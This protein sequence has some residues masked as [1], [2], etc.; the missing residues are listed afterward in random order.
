MTGFSENST[1]KI[2]RSR[3]IAAFS[4]NLTP[5]I[6]R[7]R[8]PR[9]FWRTQL[10]KSCS[11]RKTKGFLDESTPKIPRSQN[12]AEFSDNLTP[13]IPLSLRSKGIFGQLDS[14]NPAITKL[15]IITFTMNLSVFSYFLHSIC[16]L[17]CWGLIKMFISKK[18]QIHF[19]CCRGAHD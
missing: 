11:L 3:N 8:N 1:P 5:K 4:E 9:D 7:S 15:P 2:P 16:S 10:Q 12:I 13:K 19:T 6:P 14:K 18:F 17:Q